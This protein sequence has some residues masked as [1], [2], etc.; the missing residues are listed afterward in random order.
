MSDLYKDA[1]QDILDKSSSLKI[2]GKYIFREEMFSERIKKTLT[3]EKHK[4]VKE[5]HKFFDYAGSDS[6]YLN[7]EMLVVIPQTCFMFSY[8]QNS[9]KKIQVD[10]SKIKIKMFLAG[11]ATL[12]FKEQF[13]ITGGEIS[14]EGTRHFLKMDLNNKVLIELKELGSSRRYHTMAILQDQFLIVVGGWN[15]KAVEV[16]QLHSD[17]DE[18]LLKENWIK[19]NSMKNNRSDS[20]IFLHNKTWLYVFGGWDFNRKEC[21]HEIERIELFREDGNM[22]DNGVFETISCDNQKANLARY[23]M[24]LIRHVEYS[25]AL[26]DVLLLVGGYDDYYD[27]SNSVLRVEISKPEGKVEVFKEPIGMPV[28]G[29]SS[30]WYE[31]EFHILENKDL[32]EI[33]A[34]N[35]NCFNN[36]YVYSFSTSEFKLFTNNS[37]SN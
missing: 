9:Y 12:H 17:K 24:G 31:K 36:I 22:K 37:L 16:I 19:L 35:Y 2:Q 30:F 10:F 28:D 3:L 29:E 26:S 4:V 1:T 21:V 11:C 23:N 32:N 13:F 7:Q 8:T 27:Y 6:L 18:D 5:G 15:S 34:V 25:S 14:D 33:I 20:T